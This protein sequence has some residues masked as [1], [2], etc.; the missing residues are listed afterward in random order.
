LGVTRFTCLGESNTMVLM[1]RLST[2]AIRLL[3]YIRR[4][5]NCASATRTAFGMTAYI[6]ETQK[7]VAQVHLIRDELLRTLWKN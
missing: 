1:A 7:E 6:T 2:G 4:M 5:R 3:F